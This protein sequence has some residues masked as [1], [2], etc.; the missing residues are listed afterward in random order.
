[1]G[2]SP[3]QDEAL[4]AIRA[5]LRGSD[6]VFY[7]AGFAG[8]G[9]TTL[10]KEIASAV[11]GRV[12][13][14]AFTGKAALVL[15]RKGCVGASTIHSLIYRCFEV[16]ETDDA[17]VER[18]RLSYGLN[19][20]SDVTAAKLIIVDECSMVDERLGRDLLSYGTKVL[21]LGDPA[22]L[23]PVRGE[24][25]FTAGTPD[26]TL[27]EIHRQAAGNPIIRMS[28][29]V[30]E[31][32]R[33]QRGDY[34]ASRVIEMAAL[35]QR[36]VLGAD[37]I[38]VGKNATRRT[39]NAKV[40]ALRGR[41]PDCPEVGDKLVCLKNNKEKGLLNG[42]LWTISEI[43]EFDEDGVALHVTAEEGEADPVRV[44]V[45]REFFEGTEDKLP[46]HI[47]KTTDHFTYGYAL[48]VHKSQG[49]QWDNVLVIDES[50]VFRQDRHRHLYTALT[51]AAETV[52]VVAA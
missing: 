23:P 48:T 15:Q 34:G 11:R 30:R 26:Y 52:T 32:R 42:G 25:F 12:M 33:L 44:Y 5:W 16:T 17:G 8:T 6:Q 31:G 21:V 41:D 4:R 20:L 39:V 7:L 13:F 38:L 10:A 9:K 28:M 36:M 14:A 29:E 19:P 46:P 37:Q 2:W 35:G 3:Q 18:T 51:R 50:Y 27:T 45:R 22:Q 43:E 40:R 24:G 49:S 47:L 1:M